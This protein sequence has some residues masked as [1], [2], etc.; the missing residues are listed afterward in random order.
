MLKLSVTMLLGGMVTQRHRVPRT[1]I[2]S[3]M[4]SC[5]V[6]FANSFVLKKM[7]ICIQ[8]QSSKSP[9]FF[10]SGFCDRQLIEPLSPLLV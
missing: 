7:V 9:L 5:K 1:E 10:L 4:P 6:P 3:L 2:L 8:F